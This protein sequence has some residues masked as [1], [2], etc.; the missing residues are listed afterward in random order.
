[1]I[2]FRRGQLSKK[3]KREIDGMICEISD[4]Y[5]DFYVTKNNLR[6]FLNDNL[7]LLH[8]GL[9]KGDII[10]WED[11]GGLIF[12]NGF[13]EKASRKYIKVLAK[14][15]QECDRLLKVVSHNV[16]TCLYAKVKK[17][18]PIRKTLERNGFGFAGDRGKEILL[19]RKHSFGYDD[20]RIELGKREK[21][22]E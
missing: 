21:N 19:V 20:P 15:C 16:D 14:D 11:G 17:N 9:K 5:K 2:I 3:H 1:M 7:H 18:S 12:I 6:L 22:A 13:S 10:V 4:I 8:N